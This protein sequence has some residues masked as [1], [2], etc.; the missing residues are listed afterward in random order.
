[1]GSEY[2]G[3]AN[4]ALNVPRHRNVPFKT[5]IFGNYSRS[6]AALIAGM[7]EMIVNGVSTCKVSKVCKD[8]DKAVS[9]FRARPFEG[10]Y[11]FLTVDA[12]RCGRTAGSS[13]KLS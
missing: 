4:Y 10:N 13:R 12:S 6:E 2:P 3:R 8:L 9:E 1:M 5:Q 7:A 11:P